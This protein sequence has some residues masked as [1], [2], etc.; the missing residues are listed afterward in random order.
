M[1]RL[2][3]CPFCGGKAMIVVRVSKNDDT[4]PRIY[5]KEHADPIYR[6]LQRWC[7]NF[8]F[9]SCNTFDDYLNDGKENA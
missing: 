5:D 6:K 9:W 2:L 4:I 8:I 7:N 3:K 1:D